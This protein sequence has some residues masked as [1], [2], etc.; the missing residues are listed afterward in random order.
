M[1]PDLLRVQRIADFG[2][3]VYILYVA[4]MA[5][6]CMILLFLWRFESSK[7]AGIADVTCKGTVR[8]AGEPYGKKHPLFGQVAGP[9][10]MGVVSPFL[11][12]NSYNSK[13]ILK[14]DFP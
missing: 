2:G 6:N 11:K 9:Q 5:L 8:W 12:A 13:A 4:E 10:Y 1:P 14:P 7:F 3:N